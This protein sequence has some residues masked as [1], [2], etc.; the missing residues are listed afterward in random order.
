MQFLEDY[1][2]GKY[3]RQAYLSLAKLHFRNQDYEKVIAKLSNI[4]HY[5]LK[6]NEVA[7]YYFRLG[8]SFFNLKKYNEAKLAFSNIGSIPFTY[9]ELTNYCLSHMDY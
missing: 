4:N 1:P 6:P 7:M 8:Y 3:N 2:N 5:D 9:S